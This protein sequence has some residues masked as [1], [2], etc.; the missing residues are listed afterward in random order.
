M[1]INYKVKRGQI[2]INAS[3]SNILVIS[4]E[5]LDLLSY[6]LQNNI[7]QDMIKNNIKVKN[8]K[9]FTYDKVFSKLAKDIVKRVKIDNED[10]TAIWK[11]YHGTSIE[12][13]CYTCGIKISPF[14]CKMSH[15]KAHSK[16][17]GTE[18][19]NLRTCCYTCDFLMGN[20]NLYSF[21]MDEELKG[22][23]YANVESYFNKFPDQKEN[24]ITL[25]GVSRF[26]VLSNGNII[27]ENKNILK[28][29]SAQGNFITHVY[30][31]CKHRIICLPNNNLVG[32]YQNG[33]T[34][35]LNN[36][37]G[38]SYYLECENTL[39]ES[40]INSIV[41]IIG[42]ISNKKLIISYNDKTVI[43]N[44]Y[45]KQFY[46]FPQS[47]GR[48]VKHLFIIK[49]SCFI[50]VF[51]NDVFE[52]YN[53]KTMTIR[54]SKNIESVKCMVQVKK[55]IIIGTSNCILC[56]N[57]DTDIFSNIANGCYAEKNG[58]ATLDEYKIA[59]QHWDGR[60]TVWDVK[61]DTKLYTTKESLFIYQIVGSIFNKIVLYSLHNVKTLN[62]LT[63][64]SEVIYTSKH[65]II[66][67]TINKNKIYVVT[68]Q[69]VHI[70]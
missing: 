51:D 22:P 20:Q 4:L 14:S 68:K 54:I 52:L 36:I 11:N 70:I 66:N 18:M 48:K 26:I 19:E 5:D 8:I 33:K 24:K 41:E 29:W 40:G 44:I 21:I 30:F 69:A 65:N 12:G 55:L 58:I 39:F 46:S 25:K 3:N 1:E 27:Q 53:P 60:V 45:T 9:S 43:W 15:V 57:L 61:T 35:F 13:I 23:G 28:L 47:N 2:C 31:D 62:Y 67:V 59:C 37:S 49:G 32:N 64:V 17:G 6:L 63:N 38:H 34:V 42:Y 56:L 7:L 16:G 10:R 50:I